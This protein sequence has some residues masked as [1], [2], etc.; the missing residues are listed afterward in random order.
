MGGGKGDDGLIGVYQMSP[1]YD[2]FT[3]HHMFIW[4]G[5]GGAGGFFFW[6]YCLANSSSS[7]LKHLASQGVHSYTCISSLCE[8]GRYQM[9]PHGVGWG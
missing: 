5:R 7:G 6:L 9:S 4:R 8:F 3:L 1:E 2:Y